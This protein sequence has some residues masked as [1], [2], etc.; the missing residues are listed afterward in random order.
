MVDVVKGI[1]ARGVFYCVKGVN[2]WGRRGENLRMILSFLTGK[3]RKGVRETHKG[4]ELGL[5]D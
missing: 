5:R 2:V 1:T 3:C 4:R